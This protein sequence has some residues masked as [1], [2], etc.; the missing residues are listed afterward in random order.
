MLPNERQQQILNWLRE[1]GSLTIDGLS[2]RLGVSIMT[3]HRDLDALAKAGT[4]IKVHGGVTLTAPDK[5]ANDSVCYLC[6][7][8][9]Q[10]RTSFVILKA[11]GKA[12]SAC[13]PHCG[14][15]LLRDTPNLDYALTKDFLYGRTINAAQGVYLLE[16]AVGTCCMPS[17]LCFA[18]HDDAARFQKGFGGKLMSFSEAQAH[19][20]HHHRS[21]HQHS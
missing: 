16:S 20:T 11:D 18:T 8:A 5:K 10:P 9:L 1:Q 6:G 2:E 19:L 13:C 7:I 12:V 21:I 14:I 3:V 4:V 15:L 17:V